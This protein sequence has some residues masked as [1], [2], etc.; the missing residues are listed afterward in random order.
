MTLQ[1]NIHPSYKEDYTKPPL[2]QLGGTFTRAYLTNPSSVY[3]LFYLELTQTL[4]NLLTLQYL[5]KLYA[6]LA[7]SNKVKPVPKLAQ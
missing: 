1:A 3:F 4:E 2:N 6:S 5:R 7:S